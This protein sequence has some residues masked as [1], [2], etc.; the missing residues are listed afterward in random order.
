MTQAGI[1][2]VNVTSP[3]CICSLKKLKHRSLSAV[4]ESVFSFFADLHIPDA[5]V[6]SFQFT[7]M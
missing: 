5:L 4:V 7:D 6:I 1:M 3:L 2:T